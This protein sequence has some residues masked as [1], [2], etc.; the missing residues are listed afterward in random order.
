M[1]GH[2]VAHLFPHE[3]AVGADV[4]NAALAKKPRHQFLDL[5]VDQ[6]LAAAD[7]D[8]RRVAL[9]GGSEA[10]LQAH[11]ILEAGG[12]FADAPAAGTGKVAGVQR[13]KLEHHRK[14]WRLAQLVFDDVGGDLRRQREGEAHRI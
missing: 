7:A 6:R 11:H 14:L 12:I 4:N 3:H 1:R 2:I 13:L 5:R 10:V 8:H 9:R